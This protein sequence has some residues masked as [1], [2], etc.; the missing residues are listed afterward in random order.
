MKKELQIG[1]KI[2]IHPKWNNAVITSMASRNGYKPQ[3][4]TE[5]PK[6]LTLVF[7]GKETENDIRYNKFITEKSVFSINFAGK[8]A[9][10]FAEQELN[11]LFQC[12]EVQMDDGKIKKV[13]TRSVNLNDINTL[14]GIKEDIENGKIYQESYPDIKLNLDDDEYHKYGYGSKQKISQYKI[15]RKIAKEEFV[16]RFI[17]GKQWTSTYYAYKMNQIRGIS[18]KIK[19]IVN[20][21]ER[22]FLADITM[23]IVYFIEFGIRYVDENGNVDAAILYNSYNFGSEADAGVRLVFNI[24]DE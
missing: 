5:F 7:I 8:K 20:I 21:G 9:V 1:D 3:T 23:Q 6:E 16:K 22:Y 10:K 2:I 4:Y 24:K 18:E 19:N 14:L 13:H 11:L 15:E 17:E 12:N